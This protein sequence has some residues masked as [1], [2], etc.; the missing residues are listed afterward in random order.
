VNRADCLALAG[1]LAIGCAFGCGSN[2][3]GSGSG[4]SGGTHSGGGAGGTGGG[5][6]GSGGTSASGGT[7]GAGGTSGTGGS[8]G[9]GGSG[10]A[11]L[12]HV[13]PNKRYLMDPNDQPF[14]LVGDTAWT[15]IPG[16]TVT[17]A[18]SYFQ[19]RAGQ[20]FNAVLMDADVQLGASP[21]GAPE[22]GPQDVSGNEPFN[23][24]LS[25]G[26]YDVST[27]PAQG[28]TTSTAGKY[29]TNVDA[30]ISAAAQNGIQIVFDVYDN[31]N[32][33]FGSQSS[34]N[35]TDQLKAYGQFLGQRYVGF[36]NIIWMIGND[37]SESTEGDSNLAAVIEGIRQYDTKHIGWA[38]DQYGAGFDNSGLRSYF[39]LNSIYEYS[40]GPWRSL[41]LGQYNRSDY[42][43]I[44]N[45]EAGY[46]NNTSLGVSLAD[47]RNEHY[48]F[49]LN[50]AT[51]D[52]YGNEYIWPFANSW[53]D[54]QAALTSQGAHEVTYFAQLVHSIPWQNLIP[55]QTGTVF[56]GVGSPEDYS[57]AYTSDGTLALG[58]QPANGSG[59]QSFDVKLD[60]FAGQVS[61]SWFDPTDGSSQDIGSFANSGTH[62]FDSPATN[63]AGDNDFV[64]VLRTQ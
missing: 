61:A 20:G 4:G 44:V 57:G 39:D 2:D 56:Q 9:A 59:A 33:W 3:N 32:P 10:G 11:P 1:V 8:A 52:V 17:E 38:I 45:I 53:Q 7:S 18:T 13:S 47:V 36:D 15:L 46:E 40:A 54:W 31:Y 63:S 25:G 27:V 49:L 14:Y 16:L 51:G 5:A 24:K 60:P 12:L 42:G 29:W 62:T 35:S 43:P 6:S 55:D 19:T 23:G 34:P 41:Y 64:L 22:R 28:D 30:I 26:D 50:G 21:V 48:S 37:Y 58:Y